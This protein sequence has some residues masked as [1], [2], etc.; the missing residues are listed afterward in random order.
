M[1]LDSLAYPL[2]DAGWTPHCGEQHNSIWNY[3]E[4]PM[5][6]QE[7]KVER[8]L[9]AIFAADVAGYSRL[10]EQDE[11]GTLR[12]LIS[13]REVLDRLIAEYGGRIANTAGD[14]VLAEFPSAVEAVQCAVRVQNALIQEN[15]DTPAERSLQFR[16]GVHVGDVMVRGGDLLGDGVNIA[17]RLESIAEPGGV[18]LSEAAYGYARKA[19][20]L[21][22]ADLGLQKVKNFEEPVR[23]YSVGLISTASASFTPGNSPDMPP[24]LDIPSIAVLPFTNLSEDPDQA[25]LADGIVDEVT[26]AL[27]RFRSLFVIARSSAL[28]YKER[29]ADVKLVSRELGVRYVLEGTLRRAGDRV[30]ITAQLID[31]QSG[32]Y[33][34][35]DR[36]G[37][38]ITD[39]F[40]LQDRITESIIGALQ[41]TIRSSEIERARR[42]RPGN[43]HAYDYVMRA[44][45]SIW[46]VEGAMN[47]EALKLLEQ[48]ITLDPGYALPKAL[49]A[50]CHGQRVPYLWTKDPEEERSAALRLAK[51]AAR[52]DS[53]DPLVLTV[54][55]SAYAVGREFAEAI[56]IIDKAMQL[57][58][59]S[60][61]AW[62][63]SGW[64]RNFLSQPELAIEHFQRS[65]R[66][67]PLDP[68]NFD[69]A[70]GI[71]IAHFHAERFAES[72]SWV[73]RGIAEK[74]SATWAWRI[75]TA[76]YANL[77]RLDQARE[78][79]THLVQAH[80]GIT[81]AA[82][83]QASMPPSRSFQ[84][85]LFDGLRT[86]G[87][88]E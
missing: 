5:G 76:A 73:R 87:L 33:I 83:K 12:N 53:N 42:K 45:P 62:H 56:P 34:W 58:P 20:P 64:I 69:A 51:E 63:H 41:P 32:G 10:M 50:W 13:H 57:D 36:Y 29:V 86:A 65:I 84:R 21:A 40:D 71:G 52:L 81:I 49:A 35:S 1:K 66:I 26:S 44:L 79:L 75:V 27:S 43:L 14:S 38:E 7:H 16:I 82:I 78:A 3:T 55:A 59:N 23:A 39:L 85:A 2:A 46:A 77:G 4:A 74:P 6:P 48:A 80:P 60:A 61:W 68:Y 31:G 70:I 25:F 30:R 24:I 15:Q 17:A 28:A 9:A 19:L 88:P 22:F 72:A 8:R 54:L 47:E 67:S 18:C 37:G 11:L